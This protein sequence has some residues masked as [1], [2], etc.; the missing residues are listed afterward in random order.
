M[1]VKVNLEYE[2][3]IEEVVAYPVT[4]YDDEFE[5][6]IKYFYLEL[7][8]NNE[9]VWVDSS[10]RLQTVSYIRIEADE[11]GAYIPCEDEDYIKNCKK[12]DILIDKLLTD[13][14]TD[15]EM[16]KLP[17]GCMNYASFTINDIPDEKTKKDLIKMI[18][19]AMIDHQI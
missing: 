11:S 8:F 12:I 16:L 19:V 14:I 1:K 17:L 18:R 4:E 6:G 3:N 7:V 15:E 5:C 10:N 2:C 9:F 13:E